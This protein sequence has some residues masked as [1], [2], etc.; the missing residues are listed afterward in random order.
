MR[1]RL[2]DQL[3]QT[4]RRRP[5]ASML[6]ALSAVALGGCAGV[7]L[8]PSGPYADLTPQDATRTDYVGARVR[9]GGELIATEPQAKRTCFVVLALPLYRDGEPRVSRSRS[10]GR[11]IACSPGFY[12]PALYAK[13]RMITV[14][15]DITRFETRKVGGYAYRM[16]V[17]DAGQPHLW[18]I[19]P[20]VRY[21]TVPV[22]P[23]WYPVY[24]PAPP[25]RKP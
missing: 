1:R 19:E 8:K 14:A 6:A 5:A 23:L 4:A 22:A 13:G 10:L 17:L 15:G 9:W 16:P 7:P 20:Q 24:H 25:P 11:F 12:D 21:I 3:I 18:P 2:F